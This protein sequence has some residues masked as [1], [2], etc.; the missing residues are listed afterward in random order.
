MGRDT[1]W[2]SGHDL[3]AG[4]DLL[5]HDGQYTAEEYR[6]RIG[7]GHSSVE[8]AA[9]LADGAGAQNLLLF[10]HDPDHDDQAVDRLVALA[11]RLRRSGDAVGARE[12]DVV[13]V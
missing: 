4:A 5:I 7:W 10:H 2:T 9:A 3:A 6:A 13:E 1:R 12:G 11:A 8:H